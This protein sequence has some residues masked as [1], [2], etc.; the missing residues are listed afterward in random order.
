MYATAPKLKEFFQKER[1]FIWL[2][3]VRERNGGGNSRS[4]TGIATGTRHTASLASIV[5]KYSVRGGMNYHQPLGRWNCI[6][7][8]K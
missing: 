2:T 3:Y 5:V 6:N 1:T 7:S 4:K 8:S